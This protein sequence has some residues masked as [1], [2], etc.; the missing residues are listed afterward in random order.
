M[1]KLKSQKALDVLKYLRISRDLTR[2]PPFGPITGLYKQKLASLVKE[3]SSIFNNDEISQTTVEHEIHVTGPA[4]RDP[5][6]RKSPQEHKIIAEQVKQLLAKELIRPSNSP[7]S[8][9]PLLVKKP[10]G[11]YRLCIDYTK[12]NS[13]T[14]RDSFPLP[15]VDDILEE[16]AK[17]KVFSK[18]DHSSWSF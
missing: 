16:V 9:Q 4:Q 1:D 8:A 12:L 18:F 5:M 17:A 6:R 14:I 15:R 2:C 11:S 3:F 13:I 10:D 7:W